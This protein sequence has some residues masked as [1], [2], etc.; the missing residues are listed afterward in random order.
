[1]GTFRTHIVIFCAAIITLSSIGAP[2]M[3][4]RC[5]VSGKYQHGNCCPV[6]VVHEPHGGSIETPPCMTATN[7]G[8]SFK[9]NVTPTVHKIFTAQIVALG[10]VSA[11]AATPLLN[12]SASFGQN[13]KEYLSP[14]LLLSQ[15]LLI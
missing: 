9:A 3:V 15:T 13:S 4:F 8:V 2:M 11:K 1:M 12:A 5:E 6:K 7:Y 14:P 10:L